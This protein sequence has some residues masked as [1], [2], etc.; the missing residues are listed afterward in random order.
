MKNYTSRKKLTLPC[1]H[2]QALLSCCSDWPP[3]KD[4][5]VQVKLLDRGGSHKT[6]VH[7]KTSVYT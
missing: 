3:S 6:D 5:I 2:N 1:T 4:K 7:L